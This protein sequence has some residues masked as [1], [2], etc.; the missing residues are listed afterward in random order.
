[1]KRTP[2]QTQ[3]QVPP[4]FLQKIHQWCSRD[5]ICGL[6]ALVSLALK[7]NTSLTTQEALFKFDIHPKIISEIE[8]GDY[9]Y[10]Q[11]ISF[12]AYTISLYE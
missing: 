6:L 1:M 9:N 8:E 7:E 5:N 12:L 11:I 2:Y 4:L 3:N 10:Q